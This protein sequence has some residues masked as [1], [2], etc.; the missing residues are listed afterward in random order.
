MKPLSH[1]DKKIIHTMS[2]TKSRSGSL[3]SNHELPDQRQCTS[4][5]MKHAL[6]TVL[7]NYPKDFPSA[8]VL[9]MVVGSA[10][11]HLA[12]KPPLT[13]QLDPDLMNVKAIAYHFHSRQAIR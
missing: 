7:H 3:L 9:R 11:K 5:E 13:V 6:E 8:G 4:V 2:K 12:L 1:K 10:N